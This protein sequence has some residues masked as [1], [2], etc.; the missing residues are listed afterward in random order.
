MI[1]I[2]LVEDEPAASRRLEKL[3]RELEPE[4]HILDILDS[5]ES[6]IDYL[7]TSEPPD[8][9]VM[10][11]HLADGASFE[12][13]NEVEVDAPVIFTTAY[14][15]YAIQAFKVN[16]LDYLLKPIKREELKAAL[17]KFKKQRDRT[18]DQGIDYGKLAKAI[19]VQSEFQKRIVIRVGQKIKAIELREVAYFFIESR[20]T[21]LRTTEGREYPVDYNLDQ[22]EGILDPQRFFRINRKFTVCIDAIESMF[23]YTKSRV[24][25][26]LVPPFQDETIVSVERSANFK[27]WLEGK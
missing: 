12:I 1:N 27:Q 20:V 2:L 23:A 6:V 16:S 25:L 24:K 8:L 9:M 18:K 10:D 19:Q 14:D 21:L 5:V 17:G 3:I 11:I 4:A 7:K 26:S 13:F 15:E 22:L